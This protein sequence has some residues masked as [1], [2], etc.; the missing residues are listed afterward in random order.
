MQGPQLADTHQEGPV[1]APFAKFEIRAPQRGSAQSSILV[2]MFISND[3][4]GK[5]KAAI[6]FLVLTL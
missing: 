3:E 4:W 1:T 5:Q 6:W 2:V